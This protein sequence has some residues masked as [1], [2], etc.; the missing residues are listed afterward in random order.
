[1]GF[2]AKSI[3]L[4]IALLLICF[5]AVSA[6][7]LWTWWRQELTAPYKGYLEPERF[8]SIP[9]GSSVRDIADQLERTGIIKSAVLFRAYARTL[10]DPALQ[11]GEYRFASPLSIPEVVHRLESG[12]VR[13]LKLTIPEGSDLVRV[14]LLLDEAGLGTLTGFFD[15]VADAG[16][17]AD[18]DPHAGDLEGYLMPDTYLLDRG[19]SDRQIVETMLANERRFWTPLRLDRA[20]EIGMSVRQVVTLASLIEK[21]TGQAEERPLVSAVFHNRLRLGMPL[22][23]DPTVIY[24]VRLIKEYDG[25]INQSDLALDSPYNTYRYPGLPPGPI[26]NPGRAS[27]EAALFPADADYLY[28]VSR[29]DGTHVFSRSYRNHEHAVRRYQ[30]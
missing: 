19:T 1:M 16:L 13:R 4:G 9:R 20:R 23:C 5:L 7:A 26:T 2:R 22:A 25:V 17:I 30:R 12:D 11:A 24:A 14:A 21:E 8:V 28:F 18:L 27:L 15:A 29:N 10:D 6:G 3:I